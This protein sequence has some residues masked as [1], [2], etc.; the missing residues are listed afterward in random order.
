MDKKTIAKK[1]K[2]VGWTT[3][4][5]YKVMGGDKLGGNVYIAQT[6]VTWDGEYVASM[7]EVIHAL[8]THRQSTVEIVELKNKLARIKAAFKDILS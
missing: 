2:K 7:E 5:R 6:L 8:N 4:D 3:S 1:M